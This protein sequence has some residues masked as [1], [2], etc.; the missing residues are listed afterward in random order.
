MGKRYLW[1]TSLERSITRLPPEGLGDRHTELAS[2]IQ[3]KSQ[4]VKRFC[5]R[6]TDIGVVFFLEI[7]ILSYQYPC[8]VEVRILT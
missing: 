4:P 8:L 3:E 5:Q 7:A 6:E 2:Q 1:L